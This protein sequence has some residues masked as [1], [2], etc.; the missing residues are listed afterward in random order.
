MENNIWELVVLV[1]SNVVTGGIIRLL[2]IK[3]AKRKE[4]AEAAQHEGKAQQE[5]QKAKSQEIDNIEDVIKL[6]KSAL[7][8]MRALAAQEKVSM[9]STIKL[10]DEKISELKQALQRSN[11]VVAELKRQ[12]QSLNND[13]RSLRNNISMT[14][15]SCPQGKT[16][17]CLNPKFQHTV[18]EGFFPG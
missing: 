17:A 18:G 5:L 16:G 13:V 4:E 7:D 1:V 2:T 8:D 9:A 14:C 12:I 6:Y 3:A 11:E 10:Q 15:K